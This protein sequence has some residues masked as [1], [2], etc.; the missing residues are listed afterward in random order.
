MSN[1]GKVLLV[2]GGAHSTGAVTAEVLGRLGYDVATLDVLPEAEGE[3]VRREVEANG[4]RCLYIPC[5]VA[6]E[7][8]VK[9]AVVQRTLETPGTVNVFVNNAGIVLVAAIEDIPYEEFRRVVSMNLGG[10]F[11]LCKHCCKC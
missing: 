3:G 7:E 11:L 6:D 9:R 10:T 2:T 1:E 8:Q 4:R 5:D